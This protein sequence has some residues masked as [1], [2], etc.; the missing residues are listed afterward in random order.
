MIHASGAFV[1]IL[2]HR[3]TTKFDVFDERR[4]GLHHL[5]SQVV[6]PG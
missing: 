5:A 2:T 6:D 1:T 3:A 4:V